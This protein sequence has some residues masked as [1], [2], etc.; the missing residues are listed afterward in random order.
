MD[1]INN[2]L[3]RAPKKVTIDYSK[4]RIYKIVNTMN[5]MIYIG[6]TTQIL[7]KRFYDHKAKSDWQTTK[8]YLGMKAVGKDNFS[9]ILIELFPCVSKEQL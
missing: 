5:D 6:H 2:K 9:I 3:K 1:T 7:S 4:G 8:F